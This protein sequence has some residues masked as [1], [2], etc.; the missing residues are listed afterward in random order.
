[1]VIDTSAVVAI[2]CG[3]A[4]ARSFIERIE[5]AHTRLMSVANFV[6]ASIVIENRFGAEG[7]RDLDLFLAKA[8]IRLVAVDA[9]QG[10]LAREAYRLY[11][12]GLHPASLSYGDC[13]SYA[14]AKLEGEPL[15]FKGQ[16]FS[17]TDAQSA[18]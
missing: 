16:D 6:E 13:F 7:L 9:E 1:M 12:K 11:G 5:A 15:L 14:L 8:E 10:Y 2:F 4:E 17:L 3:E 18:V